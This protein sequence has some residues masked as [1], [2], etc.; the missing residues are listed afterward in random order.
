MWQD[1]RFAVRLLWNNPTFSLVAALTLALGIA[2]NTTVFSWVDG[3]LLHP[4]GEAAGGAR[5]AVLESVM[6][7][8]PNGASTLS[9]LDYQDYR[10]N[11]TSVANASWRHSSASTKSHADCASDSFS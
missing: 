10:Q 11:L 8:A 2:A 9:F 4:Y 1:I 6:P 3:V 7:S 5:L